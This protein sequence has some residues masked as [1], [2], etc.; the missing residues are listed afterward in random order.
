MT[1]SPSPQ[2][3]RTSRAGLAA[4]TSPT[5]SLTSVPPSHRALTQA[6]SGDQC[7]TF[8]GP[9]ITVTPACGP[10]NSAVHVTIRHTDAYDCGFFNDGAF[11]YGNPCSDGMGQDFAVGAYNWSIT[12][13]TRNHDIDDRVDLCVSNGQFYVQQAYSGNRLNFPIAS[14]CAPSTCQ[15]SAFTGPNIMVMPACPPVNSVVRVYIQHT[16][17]YD[18]GFFNNGVF[19]YGNPCSDGMEQDFTVGASNWS[20]TVDTRNHDIDDRVD[21]CLNNGQFTTQQAYSGNRL[22]FPDASTCPPPSG[23][24]SASSMGGSIPW[25]PHYPQAMGHSLLGSV[26]L[27]DGHLDLTTRI[28]HLPGR[29]PDL[30]MG[31]TWDSVAAQ[32]GVTTTAGQGWSSSLSPSIGGAI[33]GTLVYTDDTGA[34]WPLT[35]TGSLS[36]D[37]PYTAYRPPPGM[38]WQLTVATAPTT[39]YTLTDFLTGATMNF[40]GQGRLAATG[41]AYGNENHLRFT[42]DPGPSSMVNDGGRSLR[43]LYGTNG[44]L[45]DVKS[46]L[47][48]SGGSGQ[49]GSQHVAYGYAPGTTQLQTIT[50]AAGTGQDLTTTFGY[51]GTL[52]TSVTTPYTPITHT[53]SIAYDA[54]GRVASISSPLSGTLGQPGYTPAYTTAFT[55][56]P[57]QTTVVEG[58]GSAAPVTTVYTLDAQGQPLSVQ[59]ALGNKSSATYDADHDVTRR[60]DARGNVT[61]YGYQY[62]G[63]P[64]TALTTTGLL[65]QTVQPPVQAYTALNGT[66]TPLTTTYTYAPATDNLTE[67]DLPAGGRTVYGYDGRHGVTS[68]LDALGPGSS[69]CTTL[70]Q[71]SVARS[72]VT[73]ARPGGKRSGR[74]QSG[75]TRSVPTTTTVARAASCGASTTT[76]RGRIIAYD[77][78][79]QRISAIDPRGVTVLPTIGGSAPTAQPNAAALSYTSAYTYSAQGDLVAASTPPLTTTA[80]ANAPVTTSDTP[81]ADGNIVAVTSPNGNITADAY[82]HLGR[83][84]ATTLPPVPLF[85]GSV[86]SPVVRVS[87]DGDGNL[88]QTIDPVGATTTRSYDPLGHLVSVL[89]PVGG[90]TLLTYTATE[91]TATQNPATNVT[92][93]AYDAAGRRTGTT[94]PLGATTQAALDAYGNSTTITTPLTYGSALPATVAQRVYDALNRVAASGVGGSGEVTPTLPQTTTTN[95]DPDGNVAQVGDPNGN[96]TV[97]GYD[98]ADQAAGVTVYP[99]TAGAPIASQSL[100]LDPAGEVTGELDFND[101]FHGTAY[102][103]AGRATLRQDCWQACPAT[104]PAPL[105]TSPSYDPNGNVVGLTRQENG[106]TTAQSAMVYNAA[107]WLTSQADRA[108]GS[109]GTGYGYDAAGRL[110]TQSLLGGTASMTATLDAAGRTTELDDNAAGAV[111]TSLFGYTPNDQPYTATLGAGA[112]TAISETRQYDGDNRLTQLTWSVAALGSSPLT[113]TYAYSYTPQGRT[114]VSVRTDSLGSGGAFQDTPDAHGRLY[115][116]VPSDVSIG[117]RFLYDGNDNLSEIDQSTNLNVT[118]KPVITYAYSN[119]DGSEPLNWLPNELLSVTHNGDFPAG[120]QGTTSYAYDTVGNTTAITYPSG[121]SDALTYDAAARLTGTVR[122]DGTG[123]AITYNARGLRA[124]YTITH[125]GQTAPLFA[126]AFGYRG[127]QVGQVVVT[128]T[129]LTATLTQTYLYRP[130]GTPLELLQQTGGGPVQRYW[131]V[132]DG[133]GN[134]TGLIDGA[135]GQVVCQYGYDAWGKPVLGAQDEEGHGVHQPLRYRGYW[136]DGWGTDTGGTW[137]SA[138]WR[139][140]WLQARSYDPDLKRFLQPD[141]S[142]RDGVRTYVYCHDAPLDCADPSGLAGGEGGGEPGAGPEP[143]GVLSPEA[144]AQADVQILRGSTEAATGSAWGPVVPAADTINAVS[145]ELGSEPMAMLT[146]GKGWQKTVPETGPFDKFIYVVFDS[147][148]DVIMKP[149]QTAGS[150]YQLIARFGNYALAARKLRLTSQ[151]RLALWEV[152]AGSGKQLDAIENR[153]R[154]LLEGMGHGLPWENDQRQR[155]GRPGSGIPFAGSDGRWTWT[156]DPQSPNHGQSQNR[157]TG[158]YYPQDPP[159]YPPWTPDPVE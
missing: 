57:G 72:R 156:D 3:D 80:G 6:V 110:R 122:S 96:L 67:V 129:T 103:G 54:Q 149:G 112:A 104:G 64:D 99:A 62:V 94:D 84:V 15:V 91:L 93:Y 16:D 22:T 95:Y 60:T 119:T 7:G 128:G 85:D 48:V 68:V 130:D 19:A 117:S 81:D 42:G 131:Y 27:S 133:K 114:A 55:Y 44:L 148:T 66:L 45:S 30:A 13:D 123:L 97:Y 41:D 87:Y 144:Q 124:S 47:W 63:P 69:G 141:P 51:S 140:D 40:D 43:F 86:R 46:P 58:L 106:V 53:W 34:A 5:V 77:T 79:G 82:D 59:D 118:Q 39:A 155:L 127:D 125:T 25:M 83:P 121:L 90:T 75:G 38:P 126:E 49:A 73:V 12:V 113:T 10:V 151:L 74:Q 100:T 29:G 152:S 102:D 157:R 105:A 147:D 153:V 11:A 28:M 24:P 136:Y 21:L 120:N 101:R 115:Q 139:W 9:N 132:V 37:G 23:P 135:T 158:A 142:M 146:L 35:Y 14:T 71:S 116:D 20:I 4:S 107:G 159:Y 1:G 2:A 92:T 33:T 56:T 61:S 17:A 70:A 154:G 36:A 111:A 109:D 150:R 26:D 31:Q 8:T 88:S 138:P 18:C 32:A 89:N 108:D 76:W 134:V 145:A 78:H 137:D 98:L 143:G 52:L 65:T 50:T